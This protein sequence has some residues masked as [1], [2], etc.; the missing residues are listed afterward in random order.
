[1]KY[2]MTEEASEMISVGAELPMLDHGYLRFVEHWGSDERVVES[3]RMSTAKAAGREHFP[4]VFENLRRGGPEEK[5]R[6]RYGKEEPLQAP[7]ELVE[8]RP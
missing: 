6:K 4:H 3:A 1:M 7:V 8:V 2:W 5:Y